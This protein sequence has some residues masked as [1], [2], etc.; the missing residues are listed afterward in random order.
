LK[1]RSCPRAPVNGQSRFQYGGYT[2]TLVEAWPVGW[3]YDHDFFIDFIDGEYYL[4]DLRHP[5]TFIAASNG[6]NV[7]AVIPPK[8]KTP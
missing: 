6:V 2:F 1:F 3:G 7:P 5:L 4:M 8:A